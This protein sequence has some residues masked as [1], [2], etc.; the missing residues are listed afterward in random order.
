MEI[1]LT[2]MTSNQQS[3]GRSINLI[4]GLPGS[5]KTHYGKYL[6][7]VFGDSFFDDVSVELER[8]NALKLE[9]AD[10]RS[11]IVAD[12][13]FC[14][15]ATLNGFLRVVGLNRSDL[16]LHYFEN[17]LSSC[18]ANLRQRNDGRRVSE[19]FVK[20]LS[21]GYKIPPGAIEIPCFSRSRDVK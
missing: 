11:V 2:A 5:G 10:E 18:L 15:E 1:P 17:D 6:S 20:T 4:I 9:L 8:F 19:F 21:K 7:R 16:S 3:S 14:D 12:P 13:K